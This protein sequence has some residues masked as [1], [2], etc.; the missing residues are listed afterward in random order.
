MRPGTRANQDSHVL[1]Y[2]AFSIYF[3]LR[4]FPTTPRVL[5]LFAEFLLRTFRAAKSVTNTLSSVKTFH[6]L[7]GLSVEAFGDYR[8]ELYV[9]ALRPTVRHVTHQ[10]PPLSPRVLQQ[11]CVLARSMGPNGAT[12]AALLS[13][14]FFSMARLSSL[15][16]ESHRD[17]DVSRLPTRGDVLFGNGV[18][19][20]RLKWGKNFQEAS[21]GFWVPLCASALGAACPVRRLRELLALQPAAPVTSPLFIYRKGRR[22]DAQSARSFTKRLARLWLAEFLTALRLGD[23]GFTFH[24]FRRGACSLAFEGGADLQDIKAL[25]GWKSAAVMDYVPVFSARHRAAATLAVSSAQSP[26]EL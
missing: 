4:D 12:F 10:A 25:G 9:R 26:L 1:L 7:L 24:S 17:F 2:I 20:L 6:R 19:S 15:L 23:K 14:A 11:L 16:P 21:Q 5:Q 3:R 18:V 8:M 13:V 22:Q